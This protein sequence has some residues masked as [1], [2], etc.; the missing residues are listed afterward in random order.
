MTGCRRSLNSNI[1]ASPSRLVTASM[2]W[3]CGGLSSVIARPG[4]GGRQASKALAN[5]KCRTPC[6]DAAWSTW[7]RPTTFVRQY[8]GSSL[9]V[10]S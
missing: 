1:S 10:K 8:S 6:A 2:C 4:R 9:P 5:T 7:R 3:P